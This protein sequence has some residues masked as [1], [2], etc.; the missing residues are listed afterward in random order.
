M[1]QSIDRNQNGD[2]DKKELSAAFAQAGVGVSNARLERFFD[3]IDKDHN[4]AISYEEWRGMY[5]VLART[6]ADVSDFL[7]FLPAHSRG[8]HAVLSYYNTTTKVTAEGDVAISD[9]ALQGLGTSTQFLKTSLFGALFQLANPTRTSGAAGQPTAQHDSNTT[10]SG[11]VA[12]SD[13][14]STSSQQ[15]LN[16]PHLASDADG[17]GSGNPLHGEDD[18][19]IALRPARRKELRLTDF[20]PDVGYFLAGGLSGITSRTATAPLDRLKVYLIAQTGSSTSA[21]AVQAAK[22]GDPV[23]ATAHGARTLINA[24]KDLWAAGGIRSLFAGR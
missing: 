15:Q 12:A 18:P 23:K 10:V 14:E 21:T 24:C 16:T 9:D 7:L 13:M 5:R 22:A 2:L 1:F 11:T 3:Y 4:G 6:L 19:Y 17:N 20:I 8:L